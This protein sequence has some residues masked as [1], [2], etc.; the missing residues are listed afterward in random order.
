M[1]IFRDLLSIKSFRENKAEMAVR[2]QRT[3][4]AEA[5]ERQERALRELDDYRD[6]ATQRER[7]LY[8]DLCR[9]TVRLREIE[10]VQLS[11]GEMRGQ[12]REYVQVQERAAQEQQEQEEELETCKTAHAQAS[13]MKEKFVEL[14]RNY[15]EEEVRALER[16][17]DA[18]MEEVAELRRDRADW[19]DYSGEAA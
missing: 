3:V 5:T 6:W 19:L 18:E 14:A 4:L 12:E 1:S 2:K 11:V 13:R 7:E 8:E 17:E 10:D 9:K 15:A 16:K